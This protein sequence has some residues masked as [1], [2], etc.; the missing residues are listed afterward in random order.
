MRAD[1]PIRR[2]R[3]PPGEPMDFANMRENGV[4]S[5]AVS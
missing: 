1:Q 4:H 5:L 3:S 2:P